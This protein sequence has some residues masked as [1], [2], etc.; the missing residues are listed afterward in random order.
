MKTQLMTQISA[1]LEGKISL[2][3]LVNWAEELV[4]HGFTANPVETE[5]IYQ[6][7]IADAENFELSWEE[8]SQ[9]LEHLGYKVR[10]QLQAM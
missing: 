5:I 8:F 6:L 4:L 2:A 1:Y 7:G 3:E 9:M 10:I